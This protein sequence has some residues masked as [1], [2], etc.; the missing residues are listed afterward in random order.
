MATDERAGAADGTDDESSDAPS[1]WRRLLPT[2][3][4]G[5]A[6]LLFCASVASAFTGA[7]LYAFYEYRLGQTEDRVDAFEAGFE[8]E[9]DAAV[10]AIGEER[11]SAVGQVQSQLDDLEKFAASGETLQGLLE[12]ASPSVWFVE[13]RD[14]AGQP[15]VGAAFV[16]F[17]DGE[18]SF[19][20]ASYNTVR[21]NTQ[22]PVPGITVRK[23]DEKLDAQ[24]VR[25]DEANDLALLAV[26]KPNLPP[27][28]WVP[29]DPAPQVGDRVFVVSGLGGG[30]GAVSQGFI[31]G[32]SSEGIQHD[33][34][35]GAAFQGGPLVNSAGEV[36]GVA[37]RAYSPLHFAPEAVFFAVPIRNS[38][39][40]L[41]SC[42]DSG[43]PAG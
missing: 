8:D 13:T 41:I 28:K 6:L 22:E 5:L 11:D 40:S 27:L 23:G 33:A 10:E 25:W 37:S 17:A 32:V 39:A 43:Q 26:P 36:L 16:A 21:A 34:P 2:T 18:Q 4:L 19:L 9:V 15:A 20:I 31:A 24:L 3:A 7:V 1:G 35:V 38:C 30:G 29:Q 42:P 14:E 12:K